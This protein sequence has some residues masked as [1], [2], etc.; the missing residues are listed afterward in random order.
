MQ[1]AADGEDVAAA[2]TAPVFESGPVRVVFAAEYAVTEAELV[3]AARNG[4][5]SALRIVRR[6]DFDDH[7]LAIRLSWRKEHQLFLAPTRT[8]DRPRAWKSLERMINWLS[9]TVPG[10]RSITLQ[11]S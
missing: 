7:F 5:I 4:A 10:V 1:A 11:L 8:T 3:T 9:E 6:K 2:I